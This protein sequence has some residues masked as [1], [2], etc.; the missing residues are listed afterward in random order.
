MKRSQGQEPP[1]FDME[2]NLQGPAHLDQ[3]RDRS[4]PRSQFVLAGS[5]VL[6]FLLMLLG[7]ILASPIVVLLGLAVVL[8]TVA[9]L[10]LG[11]GFHWPFTYHGP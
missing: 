1:R 9:V 10:S 8:L 11:S 2:T 7:F 5:V 6:G 4:A 3:A